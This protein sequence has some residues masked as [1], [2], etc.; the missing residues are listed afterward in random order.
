M[1][2]VAQYNGQEGIELA[3]KILMVEL[4]IAMALAG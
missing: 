3:V 1:I 2:P 4:K